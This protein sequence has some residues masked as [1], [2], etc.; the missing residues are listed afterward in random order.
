MMA[1]TMAERPAPSDTVVNDWIRS[2]KLARLSKDIRGGVGGLLGRLAEL[3]PDAMQSR[4]FGSVI[5]TLFFRSQLERDADVVQRI[6]N[7]MPDEMRRVFEAYHLA[8]I[9]GQRCA[10]Q[11]HEWR[12]NVLGIPK[13]TYFTRVSSGWHY[14]AERLP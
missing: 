3:G 10:G 14:L 7:K 5:L 11:P 6:V 12:A 4:T 2:W 1:A 9:R 13:S 8:I